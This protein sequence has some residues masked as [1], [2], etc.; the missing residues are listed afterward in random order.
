MP[1]IAV[2]F[3]R[4][5]FGGMKAARPLATLEMA[6]TAD[7]SSETGCDVWIP[8]QIASHSRRHIVASPLYSSVGLGTTELEMELTFLRLDLRLVEI[9]QHLRHTFRVLRP[10]TIG[11]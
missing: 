2:V 6:E 4:L 10:P 3:G 7:E 11:S 8:R 9:Y 5:A 1:D